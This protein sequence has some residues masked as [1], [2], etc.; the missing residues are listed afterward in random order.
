LIFGV[1]AFYAAFHMY[2]SKDLLLLIGF[3]ISIFALLWFK[4]LDLVTGLMFLSVTLVIL[5]AFALKRFSD[6]IDK[7]KA[8]KYYKTFYIILLILFIGTAIIPSVIFGYR[9]TLDT[10]RIADVEVLKWASQNIQKNAV[11]TATLDEGSMVAYY[12]KRKNVMDTNFLLTPR[13]DQRL[14]DIDE[15]YTTVFETKALADLNRYDSK[16]ILFTGHAMYHYNISQL[17]YVNDDKCF[18]LEYYREGTS[19]YSTRCKIE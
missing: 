15:V 9:Q 5:T 10:P 18:T 17:S 4:L 7:S 12:A 16:Y 11:I 19:L 13:I 6:F 1:Y 3:G 8:H 14:A 2:Q